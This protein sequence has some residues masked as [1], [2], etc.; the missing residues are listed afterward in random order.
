VQEKGSQFEAARAGTTNGFLYSHLCDY[1]KS[2]A[3]SIVAVG[4]PFFARAL[5]CTEDEWKTGRGV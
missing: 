4:R 1:I 5:H 2:P 3:A